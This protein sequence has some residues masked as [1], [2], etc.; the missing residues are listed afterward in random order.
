MGRKHLSSN[1]HYYKRGNLQVVFQVLLLYNCIY[2]RY[3]A[4]LKSDIKLTR[5]T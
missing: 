1:L 2:V 5:G 3:Q 4:V